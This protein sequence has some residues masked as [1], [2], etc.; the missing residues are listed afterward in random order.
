MV[1]KRKNL[2]K[3]APL[4]R[5][6]RELPWVQSASHLGHE[7]HETGNMEHGQNLLIIVLDGA[8]GMRK[9]SICLCSYEQW[10]HLNTRKGRPL[11]HPHVIK[12][13]KT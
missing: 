13:I 4:L 1:G 7:L 10:Q 8:Y 11:Y 5:G 9:T 2:I 3:P 6:G 12:F